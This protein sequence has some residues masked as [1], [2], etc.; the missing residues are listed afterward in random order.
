MRKEN[1]IRINIDGYYGDFVVR[2]DG[3]AYTIF[4]GKDLQDSISGNGATVHSAMV[5][6]LEEVDTSSVIDTRMR[7]IVC[8]III[9]FIETVDDSFM[10]VIKL[11]KE[12]T[13]EKE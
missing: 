3:N 8:G 1:E 13:D 9:A 12:L 7:E 11:K 6:F 4:L 10:G 5:S 2:K